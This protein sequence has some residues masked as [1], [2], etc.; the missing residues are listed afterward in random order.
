MI[1]SYI[2]NLNEFLDEVDED[3]A[4]VRWSVINLRK[5]TFCKYLFSQQLSQ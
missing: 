3:E 4:A 5:V 1:H 2:S